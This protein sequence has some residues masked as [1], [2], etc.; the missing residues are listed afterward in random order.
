MDEKSDAADTQD[1]GVSSETALG[2]SLVA[3]VLGLAIGAF[4]TWLLTPSGATQ[5]AAAPKPVMFERSLV[6]DEPTVRHEISDIV[7]ESFVEPGAKEPPTIEMKVGHS[8]SDYL[9][10]VKLTW[11][12]SEGTE[13]QTLTVSELSERVI[14]HL[15]HRGTIPEGSA[16]VE[17]R[18][19]VDEHGKVSLYVGWNQPLAPQPP[20]STRPATKPAHGLPDVPPQPTSPAGR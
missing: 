9:D 1:T 8:R 16:E 3:F 11:Q 2:L 20:Q 19:W 10:S 17:A 7:R 14:A 5:G 12:M 13:V 4:A 15:R 18:P 6:L